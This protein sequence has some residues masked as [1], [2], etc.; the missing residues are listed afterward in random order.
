MVR[1]FSLLVKPASADCN[2]RCEYCFYLGHCGFYPEEA[3]HRMSDEVLEQMV[4]TYLQTEQPQYSFGWQG[5]EPTLMG[6]DF[7]KRIVECQE[8]HGPSGAVVG[9]GL[10][11]NAT[12]ITDEM[13]AHFA[14]YN[15]LLGVSLDGPAEIHDK[16]RITAAGGGSHADVMRSI[17]RLR[18]HRVNFNILTLVNEANVRRPREAYQYLLDHGFLYHQYISCVEPDPDGQVL[19]F[20]ISGQE[21]GEFLCAIFDLWYAG[22]TRRV[23]IRLFDS[24]LALLV[25]GVRNICHLGLNCCQ[26]FVVEYNGDVFPCDFFVEKHL[27]IGNI[28][29]DS[30]ETMQ[31]SPIY[32]DFGK[33]K[34][35]WNE[36]CDDCRF[37]SI[38]AGDCLKHRLCANRGDPRR[39]SHLCEAWKLFYAHTLPRFEELA[40]QIKRER[41]MAYASQQQVRP[42]RNDPC[43]CGSGR[44]FKKCCGRT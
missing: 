5:G 39:L 9:N 23:S 31:R 10:Q 30:W 41:A 12:L 29:T 38:C 3:R 27:R 21:W 44:K 7:F 14:K 8:R 28:M 2:L 18:E 15:F 43:P 13:A 26:Y 25:D 33:Q 24:V 36:A 19:P 4:R 16:H 22:D 17:Q 40:R 34:R 20:S 1:P 11:T 35:M 32:R 42:G 37:R 6:L